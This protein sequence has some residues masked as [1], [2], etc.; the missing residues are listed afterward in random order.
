VRTVQ[1]ET[2]DD[3]GI[4]NVSGVLGNHEVQSTIFF[5]GFSLNTL[6]GTFPIVDT[7]SSMYQRFRIKRAFYDI[8]PRFN[9]TGQNIGIGEIWMI[10]IHDIDD[11]Y[12][13]GQTSTAFGGSFPGA[14]T[15]N[16]DYWSQIKHAKRFKLTRP[17]QKAQMTVNL[18]TF[19]LQVTRPEIGVMGEA[20]QFTPE[21]HWAK[22][23]DVNMTD[24]TDGGLALNDIAHYGMLILF[25]GWTAPTSQNL[26]FQVRRGYE[27]EFKDY[28][29]LGEE[30]GLARP[31]RG[32]HHSEVVLTTSSVR[33]PVE[34]KEPATPVSF[35]T[36]QAMEPVAELPP[37]AAATPKVAS[38]G[39][40]SGY[41][42]LARRKV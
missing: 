5:G 10:P 18:S 3:I 23:Y 41:P 22:W 31:T 42:V 39:P 16:I 13:S 19:N 40:K 38:H 7:Y 35:E 21:K 9:A 33:P 25:V 8:E 24:Q 30:K 27:F 1:Q 6:T 32:V 12:N 34:D 14:F 37:S 4:S 20:A 26:Y 36:I 11:I 29:V 28:I 17:G 15:N 2:L